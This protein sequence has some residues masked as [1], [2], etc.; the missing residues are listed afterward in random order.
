MAAPTS[1]AQGSVLK[2][3]ILPGILP[4][5]GRLLGGFKYLP[6]FIA[7]VFNTLQIIPNGHAC[8][9]TTSHGKYSILDVLRIAAENLTFDRKNIDKISIFFVVIGGLV[10]LVLQFILCIIALFTSNALAYAGPGQG[11]TTTAQFMTSPNPT[12][13]LAFRMLD[14]VFGVPNI[15]YSQDMGTSPFHEGLHALFAFYSYGVLLVGVFIIIYLATAIVLETAE[16][17]TPFGERFN[18]AWAPI[19][20]ILFFGLLLPTASGLNLAQYLVLNSAKFGSNVATNA[21]LGFDEAIRGPYLGTPE[22]MIAE[23]ASPGLSSL[24]S[25]MQIARTCQYAEG[26]INGRDIRAYAA[27]DPSEKMVNSTIA[28]N[29]R[30]DTGQAAMPNLSTS[31]E[32][33]GDEEAA[34]TELSKRAKGGT[35]FIRFGVKDEKEYKSE[36]GYVF[37]YCGEL[38]LSIVDQAQPGATTMQQGYLDLVSCFWGGRTSGGRIIRPEEHFSAVPEAGDEYQCDTLGA[39]AR[40][41]AQAYTDKYSRISNNPYPDMQW[42][43]A[44]NVRVMLSNTTGAYVLAKLHEARQAQI[45]GGDWLNDAALQKGWAGAGIWFNKIAEQNGALTAASFAKPEILQMPYVMEFVRREKLKEN[46]NTPYSALYIPTYSNGQPVPFGDPT[47]KDVLTVLNQVFAFWG[48]N[49][50]SPF[51]KNMP[52]TEESELTGNI[53]IDVMNVFMGTKGLFDMCK[54]TDVHPLAQLS[55]LGKGLVE[56]AIRAF[57]MAAGTGI[58]GGLLAMIEQQGFKQVLMAASGFLMSFAGLGLILGFMLYYVIPLLPFIYFFF[59]VMTWVKGIFEAMVGVP[60]WALA[61]L[62]IDGEGMPGDAATAGYLHILEIFLRPICIL[63]GLLGGIAIFAAMV[64]VMNQVFYIVLS[65]LAGHYVAGDTGCF[66]PP[67]ADPATSL[68]ENNFLGG[69]IDEFF[70]TVIYTIIAYLFA[71]PCFKLV[72]MIPDHVMTWFGGG[73]N[74]FG[75]QDGDPAE[76]MMRHVSIGASQVGG[77]L[78]SGFGSA[79]DQASELFANNKSD[80]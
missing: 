10:L 20:L 1:I 51:I 55:S 7:V 65:N 22:N 29:P 54:N 62:H 52:D 46:S 35:I 23:P 77:G 72:D 61:H 18:K 70:Y 28:A 14:L 16:S 69:T 34:L 3:M 47:D 75:S 27:F 26:R 74:T 60:L 63:I 11:P 4:R 6:Y 64:K 21:W 19:R 17:G 33:A 30:I 38:A 56:H 42:I 68:T 67:G 57:A 2:Y 32:I 25:F 13:D 40:Q 43:E 49:A 79:M 73:I 58:G 80:G 50:S 76:G 48:T 78:Q 8:L 37:P 15:F 71:I 44:S 12:D 53:I 24:I 59:A 36:R 9:L 41:R 45:D 31:I 39:Y 5:I 66:T